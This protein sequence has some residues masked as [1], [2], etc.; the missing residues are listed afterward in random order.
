ML[1]ASEQVGV[2]AQWHKCINDLDETI[3]FDLK[4]IKSLSKTY[5]L[6]ATGG[7]LSAILHEDDTVTENQHVMHY[8]NLLTTLSPHV[9][10]FARTSPQQKEFIIRAL[11][12]V[13][14]VTLMCGDG[15]N[16]VG[17]LKQAHIGIS[18]VS[19]PELEAAMQKATGSTTSRAGKA[20]KME[21]LMEAVSLNTSYR[22]IVILW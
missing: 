5:A 7:A 10:V 18:I 9:T 19:N 12:Q 11:N 22:T 1:Q 4:T 3:E 21:A 16:D 2:D 13:G 6:C 8:M 15:T 17:A 14:E 20:E